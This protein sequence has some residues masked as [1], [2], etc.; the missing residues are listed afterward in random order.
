MLP[1]IQVYSNLADHPKIYALVDRM[2][3][4]RNSEAVG[5]VVSLWLWAAKNAPDGDLSGFPERAIADAVGYSSS[6]AE[7]LC[8]LLVETRWLDET[9]NGYA[10]HDWVEYAPAI[11]DMYRRDK[12]AVANGQDNIACEKRR[13]QRKR[14][15]AM[16]RI[17]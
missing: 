7:K 9:E 2:K 8:Q 6:Y 13:N 14:M 12:T 15:L 5:I 16:Q 4:R 3:L 1:W 17:T 10:L 11:I